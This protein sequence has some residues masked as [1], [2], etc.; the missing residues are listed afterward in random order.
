LGFEDM[1]CR[2]GGGQRAP[3]NKKVVRAVRLDKIV[4]R[5]QHEARPFDLVDHYI[6]IHSV[7]ITPAV[8][9]DDSQAGARM[10][11]STDVP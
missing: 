10:H 5:G 3:E 7:I 9:I 2:F 6:A 4:V 11:G 8:A 1:M